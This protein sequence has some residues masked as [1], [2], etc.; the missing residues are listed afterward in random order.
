MFRLLA[1]LT[2]IAALGAPPAAAERFQ[3]MP[4][5]DSEVVFTSKAPMETFT[6][7]TRQVSGWV[8]FDPAQL[9]GPLQLE[10]Q[11]QLADFDTGMKKRNQHMRD[12]H[13]ETGKYPVATFSGSSVL[14]AQPAQLPASGSATLTI[15]GQLDLHG[16]SQPRDIDLVVARTAAGSLKVSG[17]FT[18]SLSA[19]AIERPKF[20]VMKLADEQRVSIDLTLDP[21]IKEG[22]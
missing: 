7:K 5:S 16:V 20:L 4:T 6:G 11:V 3:I 9:V 12:N 10:I 14:E 2:M 13:L 18:V 1:L 19:H 8:D 21:A 22:P 15:H 17:E